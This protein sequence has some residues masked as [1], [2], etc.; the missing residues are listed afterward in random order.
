MDQNR[1]KKKCMGLGAFN[2]LQKPVDIN[3]LSQSLKKAYE[4]IKTKQ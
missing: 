4:K 3:L 1:I 2:Y